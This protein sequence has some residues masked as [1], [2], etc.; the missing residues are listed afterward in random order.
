[1]ILVDLN[2]HLAS[3]SS[4]ED[5]HFFASRMDLGRYRL[6]EEFERPHYYLTSKAE[7]A[8]AVSMG[9]KKAHKRDVMACARRFAKPQQQPVEKPYFKMEL[10]EDDKGVLERG[11]SVCIGQKRLH[12]CSICKKIDTWSNTWVWEGSYAQIEDKIPVKKYCSRPCAQR[13]GDEKHYDEAE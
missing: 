5:L 13:T 2:G 4:L 11:F 9:A 7:I 3:D 10:N 12:Q 8:Q 6:R 1:V